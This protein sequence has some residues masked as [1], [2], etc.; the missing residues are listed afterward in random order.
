LM[1]CLRLKCGR[2]TGQGQF[3]NDGGAIISLIVLVLMVVYMMHPDNRIGKLIEEN[4]I[5]VTWALFYTGL[6]VAVNLYNSVKP[7][8]DD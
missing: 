8:G 5:I 3:F 4:S 7:S 1:H 6:M 2:K